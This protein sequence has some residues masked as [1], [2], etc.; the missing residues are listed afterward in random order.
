MTLY[1]EITYDELISNGPGCFHEQFRNGY[2]L[3]THEHGLRKWFRKGRLHHKY[4]PAL[5]T[6]DGFT[7]W[8]LD[9]VQY[10]TNESFR[11]AAGLSEEE[12]LAIVIKHGNVE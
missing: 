3:V 4:G 2:T 10:R 7:Q 6:T 8:I 11:F 5:L 9:G 1:T 12:M